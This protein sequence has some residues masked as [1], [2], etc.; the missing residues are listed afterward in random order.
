MIDKLFDRFATDQVLFDDAVQVGFG[1]VVIPDAIRLH[2]EDRTGFAG[3]KTMGT[4]SFDA[5][6]AAVDAG[7]LEFFT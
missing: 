1:D 2:A 6:V 5:V 3:G 7:G 4:C